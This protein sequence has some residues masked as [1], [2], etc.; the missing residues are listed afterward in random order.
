MQA[1]AV[2]HELLLQLGQLFQRCL[3]LL[4]RVDGAGALALGLTVQ[5]HQLAGSTVR[6]GGGI[7]APRRRGSVGLSFGRFVSGYWLGGLGFGWLS[8]GRARLIGQIAGYVDI[9][10]DVCVDKQLVELP[11][12][13]LQ[14]AEHGLL[15][16]P[17]DD[18]KLR[19]AQLQVTNLIEESVAQRC[20]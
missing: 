11:V 7:A 13:W 14:P 10:Q 17:V 8:G 19:V 3:L 5:G 12:E 1:V 18:F 20:R 6:G 16:Y 9:G 4:G 2:G 15:Q